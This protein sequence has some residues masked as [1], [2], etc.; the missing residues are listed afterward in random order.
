[1]LKP[2]VFIAYTTTQ[3]LVVNM[4]MKFSLKLPLKYIRTKFKFATAVYG[5]EQTP[6]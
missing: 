3:K 4:M 1:M 2:Q 5:N 6:F